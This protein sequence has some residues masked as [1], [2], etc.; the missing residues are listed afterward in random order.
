[1]TSPDYA[2]LPAF[3]TSGNAKLSALRIN[4]EKQF[5][6]LV[7]RVLGEEDGNVKEAA[8]V[9]RM[10]RATLTRWVAHYPPLRRAVDE[11]R[12]KAN[13]RDGR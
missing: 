7:A 1:M 6:S 4:D 13:G 10:N 11:A 5:L 9:L 3:G 2:A 8:K 12:E